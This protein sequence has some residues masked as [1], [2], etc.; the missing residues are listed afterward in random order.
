MRFAAFRAWEARMESFIWVPKTSFNT[1]EKDEGQRFVSAH[2]SEPEST[3][4]EKLIKCAQY[5]L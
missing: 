3:F 1:L 4:L 5:V 2:R